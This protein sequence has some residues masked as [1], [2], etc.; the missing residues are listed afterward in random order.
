MANPK[1]SSIKQK[2]T[3]LYKKIKDKYLSL[4]E[5]VSQDNK[6]KFRLNFLK[7]IREM[8][9]NESNIQ[10]ISQNEILNAQDNNINNNKQDLNKLF[11]WEFSEAKQLQ[12]YLSKKKKSVYDHLKSKRLDYYDQFLESKIK[13]LISD[14]DC[15][16]E[17]IIAANKRTTTYSL[18]DIASHAEV[19]NFKEVASKSGAWKVEAENNKFD[20]KLLA[21]I[22][23]I[24]GVANHSKIK[25]GGNWSQNQIESFLD[26]CVMLG[27]NLKYLVLD[28]SLKGK[29]SELIK[30]KQTEQINQFNALK[31]KDTLVGMPMFEQFRDNNSQNS[32]NNSKS[33]TFSF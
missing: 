9:L 8:E 22:V 26:E 33:L 7:K 24:K 15:K 16:V 21:K 11:L 1:L 23:Q 5:S 28:N 29:F 6:Q 17:T 12:N 27:V 25:L 14:K 18:K 13:K 30:T 31:N 19:V 4:M 10:S 2:Q 3:K 32:V 20:A